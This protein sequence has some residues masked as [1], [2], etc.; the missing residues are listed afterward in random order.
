VIGD[1]T[2]AALEQVLDVRQLLEVPF[3][4]GTYL[5]LAMV[6]NSVALEPDA[7]MED[8]AAKED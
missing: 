8:I 1:L 5:C 4:V 3:V 6:F 7:D 2:W